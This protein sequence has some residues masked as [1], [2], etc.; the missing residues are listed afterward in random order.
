[1]EKLKTYSD[2]PNFSIIM[3]GGCNAKCKFCFNY[4]KRTEIC[5]KSSHLYIANLKSILEELPQ[6]F[7]QI[8]ITGNEPL[9]SSYIEPTI[10]LLIQ[11]KN[12]KYTSILLTTNGTNLLKYKNIL[13]HAVHHINISRH[14]FDEEINKQIFGGTYNISN[15]DLYEI[16]DEYASKGIHVGLNCVIDNTTS[17]DFIF[18]FIK[19]SKNIGFSAIRFRKQNGDDLSFT[20]AEAEIDKKYPILRSG[21]CPVC[22]TYLRYIMGMPCFFKAAIVEPTKAVNDCI[23]E[24]VYNTDGELYSDWSKEYPVDLKTMKIENSYHRIYDHSE[25]IFI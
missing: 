2:A 14:H 25:N 13:P 8:A 11:L 22:R 7:F 6:Q 15:S 9:L 5:K 23:Y 3:P 20:I 16:V 24:L 21:S 17:K 4:N 1:M 10:D 12:R 19:F 18:E